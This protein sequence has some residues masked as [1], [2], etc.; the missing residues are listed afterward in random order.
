MWYFF[1]L[2][3][4][5]RFQAGVVYPALNVG[6]PSMCSFKVEQLNGKKGMHIKD[7]MLHQVTFSIKEHV[8]IEMHV[9]LTR[10]GLF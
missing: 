4:D 9:L 7:A 8:V 3:S 1:D 2:L 10:N 6:S 5:E